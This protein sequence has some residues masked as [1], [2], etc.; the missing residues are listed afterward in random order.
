MKTCKSCNITN[1]YAAET[2]TASTDAAFQ[3]PTAILG[4]RTGRIGFRFVW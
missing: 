3:N 2:I 1:K 4:P